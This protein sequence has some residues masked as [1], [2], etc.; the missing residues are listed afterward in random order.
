MKTDTFIDNKSL[1]LEFERIKKRTRFT[2]EQI[3][4]SQLDN[5]Y[6]EKETGNLFHS[7]GKFF[8]IEGLRVY[9]DFGNVKSWDQPIINQPEVG[10]LGIIT[11]KFRG[12]RYFLIQAKFEPGNINVLQLSPTVQATKSNYTQVHKGKLPMFLEFFLDKAKSRVLVDR[13]QSE[14]GARFLHKRNR[15]MIVEIEED[16]DIPANY[17]WLT[18]GQIKELFKV[19]NFVNM[20]ARSVL[21]A[22]E[23][24]EFEG[25]F[26]DS[27]EI[28]QWL[29]SLKEKYKLKVEKISLNKVKD[30]QITDKEVI[31][32]LGKYFSIIA[33]AVEA[34]TREVENW[35]QPLLK[36]AGIGLA[37]FLA[38]KI[39]GTW[40]LLAQA[41]LEAGYMDKLEL[42]PTVCFSEWEANLKTDALP[43]FG[44][45]LIRPK[46]EQVKLSVLLSE[47]GGR[48]YHSQNRY[49]VVEVET[50]T[51]IDTPQ[52]YTWVSL[53]QLLQLA[54]NSSCVNVEARSLLSTLNFS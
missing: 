20:D 33:V 41:K 42:A 1:L 7:S 38:K 10:I 47:E 11:K 5:W 51:K 45:F 44:E 50:D 49:M 31:H 12:K 24:L 9:T 46:P 28:L 52:N 15:N 35:T 26:S 8:R 4:F 2:V 36:Q 18:L 43:Y 23:T 30:W 19:D 25:N 48:F 14:Q 54:V 53:P 34:E 6:F 40:Y 29:D 37:G 17:Y 13:L 16:I 39:G 27:P 22:A 3:P 32:K 21:S